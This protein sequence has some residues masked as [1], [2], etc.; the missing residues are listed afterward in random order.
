M[1]KKLFVGSL[2][3]T[4]TT[5]QLQELFS[6]VGLVS[7]ANVIIDKYTGQG[8]GFGFVEM[9]TEA[10]AQKAIDTLNGHNLGGRSIV[11]SAA[12]PQ[13]DRGNRSFG[14]GGGGNRGNFRSKRW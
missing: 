2:P 14:G 9:S 6:Q 3:Y 13:E 4:T 5:E 7:S 10:E 12:R 8:K 1:T 11:V